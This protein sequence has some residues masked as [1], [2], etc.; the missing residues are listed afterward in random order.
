MNNYVT[1]LTWLNA[2]GVDWMMLTVHV[3]AALIVGRLFCMAPDWFQ[4]SLWF[5]FVIPG[6]LV[7]ILYY[8]Y[9]VLIGP[10]DPEVKA[11]AYRLEHLALLG[12]IVRLMLIE[13]FQCPN[14]LLPS[15][16]RTRS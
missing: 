10:L 6:E 11:F 3:I 14:L 16:L 4:K 1:F 7:L 13:V 9:S 8:A 12:F 5:F 15:K 2:T